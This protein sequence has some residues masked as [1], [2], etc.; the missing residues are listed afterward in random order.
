MIARGQISVEA[1]DLLMHGSEEFKDWD[2]HKLQPIDITAVITRRKHLL[3]EA[4]RRGYT[5]QDADGVVEGIAVG[6]VTAETPEVKQTLERSPE[7]I[8]PRLFKDETL[9]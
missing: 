2:W 1:G 5:K 4:E 9:S 7:A 8:G 3:A 6:A